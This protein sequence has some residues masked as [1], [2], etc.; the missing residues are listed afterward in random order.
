MYGRMCDY[1]AVAMVR[2]QTTLSVVS[3]GV[4]I[5]SVGEAWISECL[6]MARCHSPYVA[7]VLRQWCTQ[8][9][10]NVVKE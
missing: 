7:F 8:E 5:H 10:N 9:H 6:G 2:F 1:G 4:D 3:A